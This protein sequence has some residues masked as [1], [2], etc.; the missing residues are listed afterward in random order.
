MDEEEGKKVKEIIERG[1]ENREME[2]ME[3]GEKDIVSGI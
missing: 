1:D 3:E 2:M